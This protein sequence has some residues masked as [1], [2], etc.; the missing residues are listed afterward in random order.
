MIKTPAFRRTTGRDD[1]S[2]AES[3]TKPWRLPGLVLLCAVILPLTAVRADDHSSAKELAAMRKQIEELQLEAN[4]EQRRFDESEQRIR[5]LSS[6]LRDMEARNQRLN[7]VTQ[8]LTSGNS[9]F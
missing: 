9:Q 6:E 3:G 5:Q 2:R 8:K 4:S 1:F 7:E